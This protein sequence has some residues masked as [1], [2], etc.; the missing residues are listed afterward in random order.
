MK[1][2][3]GSYYTLLS[4]LSGD[5]ISYFSYSTI[6]NID[7]T[8]PNDITEDNYIQL[9]TTGYISYSYGDSSTTRQGGYGLNIGKI[10]PDNSH[11]IKA[12]LICQT[13]DTSTIT[14]GSIHIKYVVLHF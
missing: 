6:I 11:I 10:N 7:F 12:Q 3:N 14:S 4:K 8:I 9:L 1:A 2:Y 13:P 5:D